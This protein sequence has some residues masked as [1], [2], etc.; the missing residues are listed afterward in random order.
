MILDEINE[1]KLKSQNLYKHMFLFIFSGKNWSERRDLN[2]RPLHPQCS[3]LPG[4][5]T[6]RPRVDYMYVLEK[7]Q[8]F[9]DIDNIC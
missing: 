9:K 4:C 6:L 3:A 7:Y 2:P 5:A 8:A 1:N